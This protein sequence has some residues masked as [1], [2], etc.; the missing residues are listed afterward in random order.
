MVGIQEPQPELDYSSFNNSTFYST[1]PTMES[2][3]SSLPIIALRT[4][5]VRITKGSTKAVACSSP[6][7]KNARTKEM[8]AAKRRMLKGKNIDVTSIIW[9]TTIRDGRI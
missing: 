5:I 3:K 6:L 7:S 4:R 9:I 1:L 2:N 8:K